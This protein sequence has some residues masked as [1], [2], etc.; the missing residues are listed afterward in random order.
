MN[1]PAYVIP[2][3]RMA[4][5]GPG[6]YALHA[7]AITTKAGRTRVEVTNGK[8]VGILDYATPDE[9]DGAW[10]I[11]AL[12]LRHLLGDEIEPITR[13]DEFGNESLI[14]PIPHLRGNTAEVR[15]DGVGVTVSRSV[16]A[17]V[18]GAFPRIGLALPTAPPAATILVNTRLLREA[19]DAAEAVADPDAPLA[20]LSVS[21]DPKALLVVQAAP[22]G[23]E[24]V[25][26]ALVMGVSQDP[27]R[28]R[29]PLPTYE[30]PTGDPR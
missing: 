23:R 11:D 15:V 4:A 14:D 18:E 27:N 12:T 25:F 30:T 10:L 9:P 5:C 19:L 20:W 6:R 1:I 17:V 3:L 7:A 2:L 21:S 24:A 29:P 28:P 16:E 26:T 22:R 8:T 13:E